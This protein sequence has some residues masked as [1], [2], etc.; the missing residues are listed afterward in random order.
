MSRRTRLLGLAIG[1]LAATGG[2]AT[3]STNVSG[4]I[5]TQ[6]WTKP[7]APYRVTGAVTVPAGQVLTIQPGVDVLFDADAPLTVLGQLV[8]VGTA[9]DSIRFLKGTA[10]E[11]GGIRISGGDSSAIAYARVSNGKA[12]GTGWPLN[13]GGGIAVSEASTRLGLANVV[14][15]RNSAAQSGGGLTVIGA[16]AWLTRCVIARNAA[17]LMGSAA[18]V[19]QGGTAVLTNCTIAG[20]TGSSTAIYNYSDAAIRS[21]VILRNSV[22]WDDTANEL[23]SIGANTSALYCVVRAGVPSG[24]SQTGTITADPA[25]ANAAAGDYRPTFG[26]STIDA[27]DPASPVDPDGTRADIGAF[28]YDQ[29]G[30]VQRAGLRYAVDIRGSAHAYVIAYEGLTYS[31]NGETPVGVA[32]NSATEVDLSGLSGSAAKIALSSDRG[33]VVTVSND[34]GYQGD[35][36]S[37]D[38]MILARGRTA[39]VDTSFL[40]HNHV[41]VVSGVA[42]P[43]KMV[44]TA[45]GDDANI[46]ITDLT[47]GTD[48]Q[49]LPTLR[50]GIAAVVE[51]THPSLLK[52]KSDAPVSVYY[53]ILNDGHAEVVPSSTGALTGTQSYV[54]T[55]QYLGVVTLGTGRLRV[56]E[57]DLDL[58]GNPFEQTL[59]DSTM[60]KGRA[61]FLPYV[62]PSWG[63]FDGVSTVRVEGTA[64]FYTFAGM[65]GPYAPYYGAT[66]IPPDRDPKYN[67]NTH[68]YV[69]SLHPEHANKLEVFTYELGT[70]VT[71][72]ETATG[73]VLLPTASEDGLITYTLPASDEPGFFFGAVRRT[74]EIKTSRPV[75]VVERH[76][77]TAERGALVLSPDYSAPA[78][79]SIARFDVTSVQ[80]AP[81]ATAAPDQRT[82]YLA[83]DI[84]LIDVNQNMTSFTL[85][86]P[87]GATISI[88]EQFITRVPGPVPGEYASAEVKTGRYGLPFPYK[89]GTYTLTAVDGAGKASEGEDVVR[90]LWSG[91][92]GHVITPVVVNV[93]VPGSK[94]VSASPQYSW[95]SPLIPYASVYRVEVSRDAAFTP[96][97]L[98]FGFDRA[99]TK[100]TNLTQATVTSEE[101]RLG[102]TYYWRVM[103]VASTIE[104]GEDIQVISPTWSFE[105]A[106]ARDVTPPRFLFD[107]TIVAQSR[108]TLTVR[109]KND[110]STTGTVLY[111]ERG[112]VSPEYKAANPGSTAPLALGGAMDT[113]YNQEH[114]VTFRAQGTATSYEFEVQAQDAVGNK[115]TSVRVGFTVSA[116]GDTT[117]PTFT[118]GPAVVQ[119]TTAKIR[120]GWSTNEPTYAVLRWYIKGVDPVAQSDLVSQKQLL[121][122]ALLAREMEMGPLVRDTVY[123]Y[124]VEVIDPA[125]NAT[126]TPILSART[127]ASDDTTA[128]RVLGVPQAEGIAARSAVITWKTN[129][130]SYSRVEYGTAENSLDQSTSPAED[131][132]VDNH[133]VEL[134]GLTPNTKY[135]FM[136]VSTDGSH[137]EGRSTVR[138]FTTLALPDTVGPS[139]TPRAQGG[140]DQGHILGK[141][142]GLGRE[143]AV[144]EWSSNEANVGRVEVSPDSTRRAD[145]LFVLRDSVL[146]F[147][148]TEYRHEHR[149]DLPG[150][151]EGKRYWAMIIIRDEAGNQ[152]IG[153]SMGFRMPW[154]T[155]PDT[156]PPAINPNTARVTPGVNECQFHIE[157]NEPAEVVISYG[158]QHYALND[159]KSSLQRQTSHDITLSELA[160]STEYFYVRQIRDAAGNVYRDAAPL[161]FR[162]LAAADVTPP[163]F[164]V[165]PYPVAITPVWSRPGNRQALPDAAQVDIAWQTDEPTTFIAYYQ[166]LGATRWETV[167]GSGQFDTNHLLRVVVPISLQYR[168]VLVAS[169]VAGNETI[170]PTG[171]TIAK[172][173]RGVEIAGG[174]PGEGTFSTSVQPDTA[175]P[176][177]TSGPTVSTLGNGSTLVTWTTDELAN[178]EV[179]YDTLAVSVVAGKPGRTA[180]DPADTLGNVVTEES[181][182]TNHSIVVTVQ[183]DGTFVY[184]VIS[185]D[186]AGN[187]TTTEREIFA[188][189]LDIDVTAPTITDG[190]TVVSKT[191]NRA[192]VRWVTNEPA[193]TQIDVLERGLA[194]D[195]RTTFQYPELVTEHIVTVTNL[196]TSTRYDYLTS[197]WDGSN[198]GPVTALSEFVT[199]PAADTSAPAITQAP[200]VV[201]KDDISATIAWKTGEAA[202]TYIDYGTTNAYGMVARD[203]KRTVDHALVLTNLKQGTKYYYRIQ[204]QDASGNTYVQAKPDSFITD[205]A[206]DATPPGVPQGFAVIAGN[207]SMYLSWAPNTELDFAGCIIERSRDGSNWAP[208][209]TKIM[210]GEYRDN[211]VANSTEYWYRVAAEDNSRLRNRSAFTA[212]SASTHAIPMVGLGPSA[213]GVQ[214]YYFLYYDLATKQG[215]PFRPV[216]RIGN[217]PTVVRPA[218]QP[219]AKMSYT[220]IVATDSLFRGVFVTGSNVAPGDTIIGKFSS[221]KW[222]Y[223]GDPH[224][225]EHNPDSTSWIPSR[226]LTPGVVYYWKARASDGIFDGSW[227]KTAKFGKTSLVYLMDPERARYFHI[228]LRPEEMPKPSA[229]RLATFTAVGQPGG[230]AVRWQIEHDGEASGVMLLRSTSTDV[231]TF[232]PITTAPQPLDASFFDVTARAGITYY[233]RLEVTLNGGGTNALGLVSGQTGLPS[234]LVLGPNSPNPFN[235]LTMI[236][237]ALPDR[238]RV[239][240]TIVDLNGRHV[241]TL[242]QNRIQEAGYYRVAWD[243][244][245][246]TGRAVG[247]GLY[248]YRL[249]RIP[250]AGGAP[251]SLMRRMVIVR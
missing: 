24:V 192:V 16:R 130:S 230:I 135:W 77:G 180:D 105:T 40:V 90:E 115:S 175:G 91:P 168:A 219:Q 207:A 202:D 76:N 75:T 142:P 88:P 65:G 34:A 56:I 81:N 27:G 244:S 82:T 159:V 36:T 57:R 20:N 2:V 43:G 247:S 7:N 209:A 123:Y 17:Q 21:T 194:L 177:V 45:Q 122:E 38:A 58:D 78:P 126:R 160:P 155:P 19:Y 181:E 198:N 133:R 158:T 233:Y 108:D 182:V 83:L 101:L 217:V 46:A 102:K 110:E 114:L 68:F 213:P 100:R 161:S 152:T 26:S 55:P 61:I 208:I 51:L 13:M 95:L 136:A 154:V 87:D 241:K 223:N 227:S 184:E 113:V 172:T 25:F 89:P 195:Q 191:N 11:W 9:T 80:V 120:I 62:R 153:E 85:K 157:L 10:T 150:L 60:P 42:Y 140:K 132:L 6:T 33:Y 179:H 111:G 72:R 237:Y 221:W 210:G 48:T 97:S 147:A 178:G 235:P 193:S 220:F 66:Y 128:P 149:V 229:I 74:W 14:I 176:V 156:I 138:S 79:P 211:M 121:D 185:T 37:N 222:A 69:Q 224:R 53:G 71:I 1:M 86:G 139:I 70:T 242:V 251:E 199:E 215:E 84:S 238:S 137:N 73:Q 32:A 165:F 5:T 125:N 116:R 143:N 186:A 196:K 29:S 8:A 22:L 112:W 64:P 170:W 245:D 127:R 218:Q 141:S 188:G 169:D 144:A 204:A 118:Y 234:E 98:V 67:A 240:L 3:A 52:V 174:R 248:V 239:T 226:N 200:A 205:S 203:P 106:P 228:A 134:R 99:E 117:K 93:P 23:V 103:S 124:Q 35:N 216:F 166:A 119:R 189:S 4:T 197:S 183:D 47:D 15:S 50:A 129:E 164:T 151:R 146:A 171:A 39:Y 173:T 246:Q 54:A 232:A 190:P 236:P 30:V 18:S 148:V 250:V 163:V 92:A 131:A 249:D 162:T 145:R 201:R 212:T 44:I 12:D 231:G 104:W 96:D 31:V 167:T 187:T 109:W 28:S 94:G 243:G 63:T 59:Y 214:D 206:A 49:V 107:P 41:P 225:M